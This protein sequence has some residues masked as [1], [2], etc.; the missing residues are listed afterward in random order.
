MTRGPRGLPSLTTDRVAGVVL[1]AFAVIVLWESRTLPFGTLREPGAGAV[2]I[3]L[4][5]TLLVC[6]LAVVG[7]GARASPV[8]AV[9]W[10][11]WRH[12]V[13]I[14]GACVFMALALE[15]LG[16]RLTILVTLFA[17]L[18]LVEKKGWVVSAVFA[19]V[20]SLGSHYLF[21]TLLRVPMPQ[22]PFGF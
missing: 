9:R 10:T 21:N 8:G 7:G 5:L 17:L 3:L 12:A 13:A 22:G 16:Y 14:L 1:A 15:R 2:P 18:S 11:E 6:S 4:A 20:F 19:V